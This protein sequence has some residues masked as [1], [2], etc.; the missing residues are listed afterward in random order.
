VTPARSIGLDR[1]LLLDKLQPAND[2]L[3]R[4]LAFVYAALDEVQATERTIVSARAQVPARTDAHVKLDEAADLVKR[5]RVIL[6][7]AAD[8][9]DA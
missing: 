8:G 3:S 5:A 9:D 1:F 4:A 2:R 7:R 6:A